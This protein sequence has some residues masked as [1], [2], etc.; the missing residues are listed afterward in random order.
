MK[1]QR[2]LHHLL[3]LRLDCTE[4]QNSA[5]PNFYQALRKATVHLGGKP[6]ILV[7]AFLSFIC[8]IIE[9]F[10]EWEVKTGSLVHELGGMK[11]E[12]AEGGE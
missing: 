11:M 10:H 1:N 2:V 4:Q 8:I 3:C 12:I 6:W 5:G 7:K 9:P